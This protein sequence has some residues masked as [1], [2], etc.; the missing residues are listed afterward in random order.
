MIP[1]RVA[2]E[3]E[4]IYRPIIKPYVDLYSVGGSMRR[5]RPEVKD[6]EICVYPK[7]TNSSQ[8]TL[9]QDNDES[10]ATDDRNFENQFIVMGCTLL[11][12]GK[13]YKQILKP[14]G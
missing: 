12:N 1:L 7:K 13:R 9:F 6:I 14:T 8:L 2:R 11:R 5:E 10:Y 4:Q 3:I